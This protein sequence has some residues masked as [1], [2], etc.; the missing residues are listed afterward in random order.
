MCGT[1][2][3][4]TNNL[5]III[6]CALC[7]YRTS[8]ATLR[9]V[10][11]SF[12]DAMFDGRFSVQ[13][14]SAEG[15]KEEDGEKYEEDGSEGEEVES[16]VDD[17]TGETVYFI[18]R[19]GDMFKYVLEFLR[20]GGRSLASL[21]D[22]AAKGAEGA[23]ELVPPHPPTNITTATTTITIITLSVAY[24]VSWSISRLT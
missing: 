18:D 11:N 23:W 20:D 10:P 24:V 6:S 9:A 1:H 16:Y 3:K 7:R 4:I 13:G 17:K 21:H 12:F 19:D 14:E 15:R 8:V 22:L 2:T 5:H